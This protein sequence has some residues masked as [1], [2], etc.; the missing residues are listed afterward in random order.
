MLKYNV[1]VVDDELEIR[2]ALSIYLRNEGINVFLA[3][4]GMEALE[5]LEREQVHLIIM[6]VMMPQMDG[7]KATYQIR[8]QRDIPIIMLS[9]KSEDT[10]KILGLNLGADDYVTKPFNPL[11][12]IARVRSQL[13]RYTTMG[14]LQP[15]EE[16][17]RVRGLVLDKR[18]KTVQADGEEIR[19][20]A[21]EFK[22]LELLM[23]HK[24]QVFSIEQIFDRV[25]NEPHYGSDNTVA[26]HVRRIREK[27]EINP[28][29]PQYLKVVWG[30][31][32]KIEK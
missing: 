11:E 14:S 28:K 4:N 18:M 21:T 5:T 27:I 13:R 9:A 32:Y 22:I 1:L 26:V 29:D 10:D 6:D 23:E 19:L 2:E 3:A 25:W 16:Q 15:D 7:I 12:L 8:E 24:G 31:G 20:T 17:I 30:I